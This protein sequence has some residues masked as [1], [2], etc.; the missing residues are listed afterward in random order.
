M[1]S[2]SRDG[3]CI[4]TS[5]VAPFQSAPRT[6]ELQG[7]ECEENNPLMKI[8][9]ASKGWPGFLDTQR[10]MIKFRWTDRHPDRAH[11]TGTPG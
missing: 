11:T 8:L 2:T 10:S 6:L 7:L 1:R 5:T 9:E 4:R 3:S